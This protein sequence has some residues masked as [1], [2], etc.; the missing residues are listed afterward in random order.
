MSGQGNAPGPV[1]AAGA[2]TRAEGQAAAQAAEAVGAP[3]QGIR[4]DDRAL[5]AAAGWR[6][7]EDP[8]G[9]LP[10]L[11]AFLLDLDGTVYLDESWIEGA[12]EFLARLTATGRR[13]CFDQQLLQKRPRLY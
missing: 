1:R 8:E 2:A 4:P 10:G 13:W 12:R 7:D 11:R 3:G 9:L 5:L 6:L